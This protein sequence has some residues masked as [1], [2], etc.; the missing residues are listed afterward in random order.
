VKV[1]GKK[2][3]RKKRKRHGSMENSPPLARTGPVPA[4]SRQ[5]LDAS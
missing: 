5:L 4:L 3:E 2:E 1:R